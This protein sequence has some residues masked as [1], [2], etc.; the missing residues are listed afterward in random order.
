M[1][2]HSRPVFTSVLPPEENSPPAVRV[3]KDGGGVRGRRAA[4][5]DA[6]VV[7]ASSLVA[8]HNEPMSGKDPAESRRDRI[9]RNRLPALN[10]RGCDFHLNFIPFSRRAELARFS[11]RIFLI[12]AS[13]FSGFLEGRE[14]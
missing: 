4:G 7:P 11:S 5:D 8:I 6:G 10:P 9:C 12:Q 1:E 14:L 13:H 2:D 3:Y